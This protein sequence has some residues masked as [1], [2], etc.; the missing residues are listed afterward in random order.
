M[1]ERATQA[2]YP[3]PVLSLLEIKVR[4]LLEGLVARAQ[5]T[6]CQVSSE[7]AIRVLSTRPAPISP[8]LMLVLRKG[9][10]G[11]QFLRRCPLLVLVFRKG[12]FFFFS[13]KVGQFSVKLL[14][15]SRSSR[16]DEVVENS[17]P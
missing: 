3:S 13:V 17:S 7:H 1:E 10:F 11:Q 16:P 5:I 2:V 4:K 8:L 6:G 15:L 14:T 12:Y 9:S